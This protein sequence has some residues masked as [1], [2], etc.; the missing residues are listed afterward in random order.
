MADFSFGSSSPALSAAAASSLAT[1]PSAALKSGHL[2]M[3]AAKKAA[4]GFESFFASQ[5]LSEMFNDVKSDSVFGGGDAEDTLRP[6]LL[7]Q[8]A[9]E[10]AKKGSLGIG[11][12]V[13]KTLLAQQEAAS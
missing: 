5:F 3:A 11:D 12:Q 9:N 2:D 4:T 6:F 8:Y 1:Q 10:I 13:M 7:D